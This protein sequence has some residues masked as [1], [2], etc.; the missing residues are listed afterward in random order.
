MSASRIQADSEINLDEFERRL[1]APGAQQASEEDLLAELVRLVEAAGRAPVRSPSLLRTQLKPSPK[2]TEPMQ[3]PETAPLRAATAGAPNEPA[4]VDVEAPEASELGDPQLHDSSRAYFAPQ[5]FAA[6]W[7]LKASALALAGA[8]L[9]G[10]VFWLGKGGAPGPKQPPFIAAAQSPIKAPP[11]TGDSVASSSDAG[12]IPVKDITQPAQVDLASSD[13]QLVDL[14]A[15]ASLG[16]MPAPSALAPTQPDAAQPTAAASA[17]SLV[18]TAVNTPVEAAPV[19]APS[20]AASQFPDSKSLRTAS[21]RP[22]ATSNPMDAPPAADSREVSPAS[23]A[24]GPAAK[25][26]PRADREAGPVGQPPTPKLDSPTKPSRRSS[27][28]MVVAKTEATA[29]GGATETGSQPLHLGAAA[30]AQAP[31][32]AEPQAES[33]APPAADQQP[34]N[35]LTHAFGYIVGAALGPVT[36]A[37]HPV[38][39]TASKSGDW[40]VQFAAPKSEA[41]AKI[42]A[43]RLTAKYAPA[44]NGAA[45][46]VHKTVVNGETTYALRVTGLSKA[47]AAALCERLKGRDCIIAK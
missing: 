32:E 8:A 10:P 33:P 24:P 29:P 18:A 47:D 22:D 14:N 42:D 28:R 36:S 26:A 21:L 11:P 35:P 13:G 23:E 39:Q 37:L 4:S 3:R 5:G 41:Q 31:A 43:A 16:N 15:D 1:R 46:G 9:V 7:P 44:L 6:G 17:G 25:R 12:A 20:P 38:D 19:A 45:I 27:A 30:T 2:A 40:A 34:A